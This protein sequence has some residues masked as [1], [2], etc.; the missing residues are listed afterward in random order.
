[1]DCFHDLTKGL[2]LSE[3][4]PVPW[5]SHQD[6]RFG[7]RDAPDK[8]YDVGLYLNKK[9]DE[10]D[11]EC[12][13]CGKWKTHSTTLL[14]ARNGHRDKLRKQLVAYT[15]YKKCIEFMPKEEVDT[16]IGLLFNSCNRIG[17]R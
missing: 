12:E 4:E 9:P 15:L 2:D 5:K 3:L 17:G 16:M 8:T 1:M 6:V 10:A 11:N 7:R 13:L 14:L